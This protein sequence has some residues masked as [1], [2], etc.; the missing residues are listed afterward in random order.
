MLAGAL[1]E[2]LGVTLPL[3]VD[4]IPERFRVT[5]SILAGIATTLGIVSRFV[6]QPI[7]HGA[8]DE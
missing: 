2:G 7:L 5:C 4:N 6:T 1:I 3:L 8:D